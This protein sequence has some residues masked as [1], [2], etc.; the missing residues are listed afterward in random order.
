RVR[1]AVDGGELGERVRAPD[2]TAEL[3]GEELDLRDELRVAA[4]IA[5]LGFEGSVTVR[6]FVPDERERFHQLTSVQHR[7]GQSGS[8]SARI[9]RPSVYSGCASANAAWA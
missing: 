6:P 9:R 3:V 5:A 7:D 2:A 1:V 4:G 8:T